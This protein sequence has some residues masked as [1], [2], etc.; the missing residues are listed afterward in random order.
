MPVCTICTLRDKGYYVTK[1]ANSGS[2]SRNSKASTRQAL[3]SLAGSQEPGGLSPSRCGSH[4]A[5]SG[6]LLGIFSAACSRGAL[7]VLR[8]HLLARGLSGQSISSSRAL[9]VFACLY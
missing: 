6:G 9:R 5:V 4:L 3:G 2:T 1:R 7:R 8:A